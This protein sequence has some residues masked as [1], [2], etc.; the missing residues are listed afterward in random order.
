M[1]LFT[2]LF[3]HSFLH[4]GFLGLLLSFVSTTIHAQEKV[5]APDL[6]PTSLVR[7]MLE[8]D[9]HVKALKAGLE[10][11]QQDVILLEN[12]PYEWTA[13]I[14]SQRRTIQEQANSH[15]WTAGIEHG[16]RLP[17]KAQADKQ[18]AAAI[19]AEAQARYGDALHETARDFLH[20]WVTWLGAEQA[21]V[22]SKQDLLASQDNV[23]SV[24]KRLRAGDVAK[25]DNYL[26]QADLAEYQRAEND[27]KTMANIAWSRLHARFP[28][29]NTLA[30]E[31]LA[32]MPSVLPL[33]EELDFWRERILGESD[34]LKT[35][36][37]LSEQAKA[38]AQRS[39]ADR[40]PDP[41]VGIHTGSESRGRE[42]I[43]GV[44]IS[45]PF[46]FDMRRQKANKSSHLATRSYQEYEL[47][48]RELE[49]EIAV[50]VASAHGN[51]ASMQI[52]EKGAQAIQA[53]AQLAQRAY[54]LGE[55]ELQSVLVARK[56]A[57]TVNL[58]F[59]NS[60]IAAMHSYYGLIIDAHLVWDLEHD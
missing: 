39:Q 33:Q 15:E 22:L 11:A 13:K 35:A 9:P 27:A 46:S 48:K 41:T 7:P 34:E 18:L 25:L 53:N 30:K 10:A 24:A 49:A 59:L 40:I 32:I 21:H 42:R 36:F 29:F 43:M 19:L 31:Q 16:I 12:S 55:V 5:F 38:H 44:S 4:L 37:A 8:Q 14:S 50:S 1:K 52:A 47:K 58:S 28:S 17:S 20:L 54:D 3:T 60:K 56:Q 57:V 6:L 2:R 23:K 51:Y 45:I 26:A